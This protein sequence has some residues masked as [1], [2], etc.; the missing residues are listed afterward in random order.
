MELSWLNIIDTAI[1]IGLGS[2]IT[3]VS[4]YLVLKRNQSHEETKET[5]NYYYKQQEEKKKTYVEFLSQSQSMVQSYLLTSCPGN[6]D[7][8]KTYLRAF[9]D[10]QIIS[11]DEVR[12]AA[13]QLLSAVQEIVVINKNG[14]ESDLAKKLRLRVDENIGIFQKIVQLEATK[15]PTNK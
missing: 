11:S 1:K 6:T 8:Y 2:L 13:Y 14:L 15:E 3:A 12:M 7:D 5:R 9:N 4:G 10:A